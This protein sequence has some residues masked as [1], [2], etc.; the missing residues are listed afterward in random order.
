MMRLLVA[1]IVLAITSASV[2]AQE[3]PLTLERLEAI[4]LANNP[5]LGQARAEVD[6]SRGKAQQ[7]GAFPNP[8]VG[9][10]AEEM[11]FGPVIQGGEH[12]VFVEQTIPLGGKLGLA[13]QVFLREASEAESLAE[14]QRQRVLTTVRRLYYEALT[15]ERRVAVSERL[16]Q[17]VGEATTVTRQLYNVGAADHP[18]VLETDVEGRRALLQLER[19]RN[20]RFTIWRQLAAAVGEPGLRPQPLEGTVETAIPELERDAALRAVLEGSPQLA[21]ARAAVERSRAAVSQAHKET[22]PDLFLRGGVNYNRELLE[23]RGPAND[24]RRVGWEGTFEAGVSLPLFN[25]NQGGVSAAR[26]EQSRAE[27]EVRRIEL[28]LESKFSE[29]FEEYLTALRASETYRTEMLPRAEQA[30]RL[31]LARYR[32]MAAAYPQVL[33]AQR[34]LLELTDEYLETVDE[35]WRAALAVQGRLVDGALEEP[36]RVGEPTRVDRMDRR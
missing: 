30:Y 17:L 24:R 7:A 1:A 34:S 19:A 13:R 28:V 12:G 16:A 9:Y 25:R 23:S 31:Y 29:I 4:A 5:T 21:A 15:A 2:R 8:I 10:S 22:F 33:I 20:R 6:A 3:A 11:S 18:D 35:A 32:E 26:A 36:G 27:L 14:I